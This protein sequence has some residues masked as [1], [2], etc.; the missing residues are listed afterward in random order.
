M[1]AVLRV[2]YLLHAVLGQRG[3]PPGAP[4]RLV[5]SAPGPPGAPGHPAP[6]GPQ[7]PQ[8]PVG[9]PGRDGR[10]GRRGERG[11]KGDAA[12]RGRVG[13]TGRQGEWGERGPAGKRG[14]GGEGGAGGPSG[15]PGANGAL[16]A[17]GARGG[18]G[19]AGRCRCGGPGPR[20]AFSAGITTSYPPEDT[21]ILFNKVLFNDG[22]HYDPATGKFLCA[23]AGVFFFSYHITLANKHLAI[24]L[25]LNGEYRVKTFDANTGN[26]DVAS[27]STAVALRPGDQVWLQIFFLDQNGLFSDPS[28]ADS[29]FSGFL[30]YADSASLDALVEDRA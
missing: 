1:W 10:D 22:G 12:S 24:G 26:H 20:A 17:R 18:R 15:F 3:R 9:A 2:V 29:V 21:P 7:G 13:P 16:G 27:G 11:E 23:A 5:C 19:A 14:P 6:S 4:P 8:G 25:V 30:L 28:W